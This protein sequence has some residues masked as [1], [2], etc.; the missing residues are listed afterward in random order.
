MIALN[1]RFMDSLRGAT[2]IIDASYL[3]GFLISKSPT[4]AQLRE[5]AARYQADLVLLFTTSC[6]LYP[7]H[8]LLASSEV[9]AYCSADSAVLDVRTGLVPFVSRGGDDLVLK[10]TQK[11]LRL[12]ETVQRAELDGVD[13]AMELNAARLIKF[14]Q[15]VAEKEPVAAASLK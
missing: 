5:A 14:L 15:S 8:N 2:A 12:S 13:R 7:Q 9:R 6:R 10:E 11:D 4:L 1:P 3:P